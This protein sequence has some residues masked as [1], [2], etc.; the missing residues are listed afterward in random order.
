MLGRVA[1]RT[2]IDA[3]R[4]GLMQFSDLKDDT[5]WYFYNMHEAINA[6]D[7]TMDGAIESWK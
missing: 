5:K 3:H 2:Y 6:H 4:S 1:D 7:Y